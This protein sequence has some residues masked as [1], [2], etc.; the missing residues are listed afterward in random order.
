LHRSY[1]NTDR[2]ST[3]DTKDN[4]TMTSHHTTTP[5]GRIACRLHPLRELAATK[6][7]IEL[8]YRT[9]VEATALPLLTLQRLLLDIA[10]VYDISTIA[11]LCWFF[12]CRVG[13]LL[14]YTNKVEI[15]PALEGM[16]RRPVVPYWNSEADLTEFKLNLAPLVEQH[17]HKL[18]QAG[19]AQSTLSTLKIRGPKLQRVNR[20][21][22]AYFCALGIEIDQIFIKV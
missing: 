22:L 7:H 5:V 3:T 2:L 20:R 17:W 19:L 1:Y 4:A 12:E 13:E 10:E 15:P 6:W 11:R 14:T 8:G 18:L 16:V 9:L 21:T